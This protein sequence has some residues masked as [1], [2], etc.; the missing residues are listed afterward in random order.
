MSF[1]ELS[2]KIDVDRVKSISKL[3]E[4]EMAYKA[5]RDA[6][7][8]AII[9]GNDQRFLLVMGPCSADDPEAVF[10]YAKRLAKL[11]E[12]VKETVFIVM[13]VYTNKPRTNGDGYKGM[14]HQQDASPTGEINLVRGM[15]AVRKMHK[16]VLAETG[17]TTA[18]EMLYPDNLQFVDD[19]VSYH[20]VGARSVENQ[21]HRFVASGIDHPTGLKNPT[22]GNINVMF[23]AIYA[24]QQK[25]ELMYNGVEVETSSNPLAHVILRG[26]LTEAGEAVPNYHYEDL[27]KVMNAYKKTQL[28]N[29]FIMVDT[30]H[31]NSGKQYNDQVRIVQ[32]VLTN[33]SWN[34][35][36]KQYVRG[37]MIESY[38]EDGRQEPGGDVFGQS[39]TDP[40]LGWDKT[41][42]LVRYIAENI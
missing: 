25:Q 42:E 34:E 32:E 41:E 5:K 17:L 26:A 16:R 33:R 30:N 20:A 36:L 13:R 31:D 27:V 19:L 6:E 28:K 14:M 3:S 12:E 18:D 29:P 40:C 39:I 35:E 15:V 23:N 22:S 7:L 4:E 37:F 11:Q 2:K 10:E 21:Q 1:K 9:E 8:K 24:A 38:L